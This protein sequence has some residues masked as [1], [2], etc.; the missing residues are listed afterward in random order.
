LGRV[1]V[2]YPR[3]LKISSVARMEQS[4]IREV[5]NHAIPV[6]RYAAYGLQV[7]TAT[8]EKADLGWLFLA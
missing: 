7:L 6:F 8:W 5:R 4:A 3:Y 2:I 1:I